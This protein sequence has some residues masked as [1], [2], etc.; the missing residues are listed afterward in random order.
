MVILKHWIDISTS[1]RF[2]KFTYKT[3]SRHQKKESVYKSLMSDSKYSCFKEALEIR[4]RITHPKGPESI[5]VSKVEFE[6]ICKAHDWYHNFI[7]TILEDDV[8]KRRQK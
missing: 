8:V 5:S 7:I 1:N 4:N 2:F 6:N 3:Y